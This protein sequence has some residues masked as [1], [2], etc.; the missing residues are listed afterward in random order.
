MVCLSHSSG[1]GISS[2]VE[3]FIILMVTKFILYAYKT[4]FHL[5]SFVLIV[6]LILYLKNTN[7]LGLIKDLI[8]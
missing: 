6:V 5:V 1:S 3:V 8:V 7:T 2:D 4:M